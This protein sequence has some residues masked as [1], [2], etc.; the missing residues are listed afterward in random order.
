MRKEVEV[1]EE[2]RLGG[3]PSNFAGSRSE[4]IEVCQ[5]SPEE[6]EPA[7]VCRRRR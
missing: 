2:A 3:W 1:A 5:R 7:G 4:T 6:V